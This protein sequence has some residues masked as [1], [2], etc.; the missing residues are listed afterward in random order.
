MQEV[1]HFVDTPT[2]EATLRAINML[3][4][5][6]HR[7]SSSGFLFFKQG[8]KWFGR[9]TVTTENQQRTNNL[10]KLFREKKLRDDKKTFNRCLLL[11]IKENR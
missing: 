6:K 4:T 2:C 7:L 11:K 9:T 5:T 1:Q 3:K 8:L 10:F